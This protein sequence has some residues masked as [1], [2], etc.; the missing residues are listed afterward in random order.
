MAS[1]GGSLGLIACLLLLQPRPCAAWAAASVLSTSG[2]LTGLSEGPQ[3]TPPPPTRVRTTK[4]AHE[5]PTTRSPFTKFSVVCGEPFMKIMGGMDA[6][7]GKWPWQVSVRVRHM[8]ICG[9]SLI[10][11]QWVLTAAHCIHSR[12]Q[13]NVKMGDRSV[14]RQNTSLVIPVQKIF[15]HPKF[16]TAII[17]KNDIALLK[18]KHPVNFTSN[19]HPVCVPIETFHVK[20]GTRCWVTGWGKPDPGA[21]KVP[22]EI[23][24]EVDQNIILYEKCNEMLKRATSGSAD[25]VKRGMI[26]AYKE[27]GKDACQGDS[28]GPLSCKFNDKWVQVGVVSWG[29]SCGRRGHPGVYTDVAFYSKWLSAVVNQ[30]A[31]LHPAVLLISLLCWL[32]L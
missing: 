6:E 20:A 32:T 22:T 18:L 31:C 28:G 8:H 15:V 26:C 9:G 4:A 12:T 7:E 10:N 11:S 1:G 19:I 25:L 24:Q 5:R 14:Y 21:P 2:F 29:I 16:S 3:G 30:S 27:G 13:Y 23:L 17:V